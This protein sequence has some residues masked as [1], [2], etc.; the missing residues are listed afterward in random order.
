MTD[1]PESQST[2][3]DFDEP[4]GVTSAEDEHAKNVRVRRGL[5]I[6]SVVNWVVAILC[7]TISAYLGLASPASIFVYTVLFVIGLFAA[8]VAI[9]AYVLEKFAH[10]PQPATPEAVE[11]DEPEPG[12][13]PS[14]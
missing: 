11:D 14:A 3:T 6:L 1:G 8:V 10:R 7:W 9:A 2:A 13:I 4:A 5:L 12:A